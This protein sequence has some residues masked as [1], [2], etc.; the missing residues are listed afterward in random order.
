MIERMIIVEPRGWA[1]NATARVWDGS[2]KCFPAG[3]YLIYYRKTRRGIDILH[4]FPG[5]PGSQECV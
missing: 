5:C 3:K 2:V 1:R 4:M